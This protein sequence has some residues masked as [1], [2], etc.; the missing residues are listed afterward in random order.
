MSVSVL[1]EKTGV[2]C[3]RGWG[4]PAVPQS[5]QAGCLELRRGLGSSPCSAPAPPLPRLLPVQGAAAMG[6]R[7]VPLITGQLE[8]DPDT[9]NPA[10]LLAHRIAC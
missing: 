3:F 7:S 9:P 10:R 4:S 2:L 5:P 6:G 8:G 1:M